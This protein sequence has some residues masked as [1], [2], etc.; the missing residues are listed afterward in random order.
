M[1]VGGSL[2]FLMLIWHC[3][4]KCI[5]VTNMS[6]KKLST[7]NCSSFVSYARKEKKKK[8]LLLTCL[9]FCKINTRTQ[10]QCTYL[11]PTVKHYKGMLNC[12]KFALSKIYDMIFTFPYTNG[13]SKNQNPQKIKRLKSN[14]WSF[15]LNTIQHPFSLRLNMKAMHWTQYGNFNAFT[16]IFII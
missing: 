16:V 12:V 4:F 8:K 10:S 3:S 5:I 13:F 2:F 9:F 15:F 14:C 6:H 7:N 11:P 1:W